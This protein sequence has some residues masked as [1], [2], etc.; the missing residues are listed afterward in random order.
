MQGVEVEGM[1]MWSI[2]R[3]DDGPFKCYKSFGDDLKQPTPTMANDKIQN[4][5]V[6]IIRDRI[7]NMAIN[8]ILKNRS[9]LRDGV[10]AEIQ[11][12]VTG[13]GIWLETVEIMEVKV[14]SNTLFKNMQTEFRETTR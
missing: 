3:T 6:S 9:K 2:Y 12:L 14:A 8:D 1:L 5:A 11:E 4:L 10:K 7:A 13:W